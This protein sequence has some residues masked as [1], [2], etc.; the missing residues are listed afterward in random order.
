MKYRNLNIKGAVLDNDQLQRYLEKVA[1]DHVLDNTSDKDTY[2]IPKLKENYEII[3]EIYNLLNEHIKMGL[4]IHPAGEWLLDNFYIVEETIKTIMKE[5]SLK[6]YRSFLGIS[7]GMYKGFARIYV[8]ATEI[9]AYTDNKI[10]SKNISYLLSSYQ[11][12]KTLSMEEIWNIGI[13]M[14]IALVQNI[15]DICEKIYYS[16]M[17]KYRVENIIER[18]VENKE[19]LKYKNLSEYKSR[20]KGYGEMKYPFIE[21]MSYR[22]KKY[23]K[24]AVAFMDILEEQVNKMGTTIDEVIQKEHFDMAVKKVSMANCIT[25]IKELL[26]VDFMQIFEKINGVEEILRNDPAKVYSKMDYKTKE[27]YR[28]KIKELSKKTKISEI[29]IAQ[30]VLELSEKAKMKDPIQNKLSHVGYYLIDEGENILLD[31]LQVGIRRKLDIK[32]KLRR[33]LFLI[34]GS[35]ILLDVLVCLLLEWQ[36]SNIWI[37]ILASLILVLPIQE[38]IQQIVKH[39][40]GKVIQPKIIPKLDF[41]N[42]VP[43]EAATF[44]VIP[45]IIKNKEKVADLMKHLEVYYLANKSENLYFALLGDCSSGPNKEELFD[46]EVEDEGIRQVEILNAKHKNPNGDMP[47]FSFIYRKRF[48]NGKEECYLGWERKRGLLNQFNEYILGHEENVFKVN[49]LE[50]NNLAD[51]KYIITLDADTKLT[52]NTGLEMIGSMEHVLNTP[53]LNEKNDLVVKGHAL[54]QPRVGID[55]DNSLKTLFTKIFAGSGGTDSYTNAISDVYQD[56]FDEGIFTGKG[57]YNVKV[58]SQMLNNEIPENT[59]LSHDLLEGSYLR[60]ALASDIMLLDGYPAN[61]NSF[62][63]RQHR[64][65]RGDFQIV[66]W[67]KN[68]IVDR[69]ENTKK[70]P[71]NKLSR[72]KIFDNLMR[73]ITPILTVLLLIMAVTISVIYKI[74]C[75]QL[76]LVAMLTIFMPMIIDIINKIVYRKEGQD[77]KKSFTPTINSFFASIF[78][79][80]I[81]LGILPD[82]AYNSLNAIIKTV[83]RMYVSK[84]NMLEW[85]TS[86]E[87]EKLAKTNLKSYYFNMVPNIVLG[88]IGVLISF[89]LLK[90]NISIVITSVVSI[91]WIIS[92]LVMWYIGREQKQ[93]KQIDELGQ[94]DREYVLEIGKRTWQFFKDNLTKENNYLPPDNYQEDR[95]QKTVPRTSSTNIGLA[96]LAVISSYD[97]GYEDLNFCVNLL[98]IND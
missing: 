76:F 60:C 13:F 61:Y 40:I 58:F 62:K 65:I 54:I 38:F 89:T 67:L 57:I 10:D 77:G 83:Y 86:E 39:I 87:A 37:S 63:L 15:R 2:P 72:Y 51:I 88:I 27:Y 4:P 19:D 69:K 85:T 30:K 55:L 34:W 23:G 42:G 11:K 5:L 7:N 14:Q 52:L 26:R 97:L 21:Y 82:S 46:K 50:G 24:S 12:K 41:Q 56:N 18:L 95:R 73:A 29:Y 28:N 32:V 71:L 16:Q 78:R 47:K 75:W 44:V 43:K 25:S 45:T 70:N 68:S 33:F 80:F 53:V 84:K 6:K 79:G 98:R 20:V 31:E 92:P 59:V 94:K 17:Q 49:T 74:S 93:K 3:K 36:I 35:S 81:S 90:N 48:W 9:V 64:W 96:M 66:Q 22:L 1:S 8:L 91:I